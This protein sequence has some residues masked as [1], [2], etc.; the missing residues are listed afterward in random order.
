MPV[1]YLVRHGQ[2]SYGAADYDRLSARGRAQASALGSVLA[3]RCGRIDRVLSG[4]M[5][6]QVDTA[7]ECL[8]AASPVAKTG[9]TLPEQ[10][11]R[12]NEYDFIDLLARHGN[13]P[14]G[15]SANEPQTGVQHLLDDA[16]QRWIAAGESTGCAESYPAF[17]AR[18]YAALDDLAN[19]LGKGESVVVFTSGGP[20]AA[21]CAR[22]LALPPTGF[23]ALNRVVVNGGITKVVHGA[24]GTSLLSFNE[25]GH[26][27]GPMRDQ[28]S[29]R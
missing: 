20:I 7:G 23:V 26:F 29:Y 14:T 21:A 13:P 1:I 5:R 8:A 17:A 6:R 18:T 3:D 15:E 4:T 10:D 22:L 12:W 16:L 28:L 25:H 11:A 24:R 9:C 27:E 19:G 2:A